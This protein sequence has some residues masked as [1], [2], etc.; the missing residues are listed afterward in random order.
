MVGADDPRRGPED[1][2]GRQRQ[3]RQCKARPASGHPIATITTTTTAAPHTRFA[4]TS[5]SESK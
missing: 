3:D 4:R 2:G 1:P 5:R